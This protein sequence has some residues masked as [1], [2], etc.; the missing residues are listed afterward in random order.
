MSRDIKRVLVGVL[1]ATLVLW[2]LFSVI[3]GMD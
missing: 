2:F 1:L 3:A